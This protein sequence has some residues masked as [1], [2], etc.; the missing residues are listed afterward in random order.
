MP[1]T[2]RDR[3]TTASARTWHWEAVRAVV[4]WLLVVVLFIAFV[5]VYSN[6]PAD[7]PATV[8]P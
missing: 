2:A 3:S 6:L 5:A 4:L 1:T 7:V 8:A